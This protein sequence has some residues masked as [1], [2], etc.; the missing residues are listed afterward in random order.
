MNNPDGYSAQTYRPPQ[1]RGTG[2]GLV[3]SRMQ[4]QL[5]KGLAPGERAVT[6]P[7]PASPNAPMSNAPPSRP[8]VGPGQSA[9]AAPAPE[10]R[11][12][13]SQTLRQ[14]DEARMKMGA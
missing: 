13:A 12:G 3:Q 9:P 14:M 7:L 1:M 10:Q 8:S 11:R 6:G 4:P 5:R 2:R